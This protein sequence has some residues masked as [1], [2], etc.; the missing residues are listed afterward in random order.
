MT[1]VYGLAVIL[2]ICVIGGWGVGL[3]VTDAP[4]PM[5]MHCFGLR[6]GLPNDNH[7]CTSPTGGHDPPL[8]HHYIHRQSHR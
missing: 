6:S 7:F 1:E 2:V 4:L 8:C 3:R 5:E